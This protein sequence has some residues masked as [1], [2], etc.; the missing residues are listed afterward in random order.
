MTLITGANPNPAHVNVK[1]GQNTYVAAQIKAKIESSGT[2]AVWDELDGAV[3]SGV[4]SS[5]QAKIKLLS[6][7]LLVADWAVT[8]FTLRSFDGI[9]SADYHGLE[10]ACNSSVPHPIRS[11]I[12]LQCFDSVHWVFPNATIYWRDGS[13]DERR[14]NMSFHYTSALSSWRLLMGHTSWNM[15]EIYQIAIPSMSFENVEVMI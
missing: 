6:S 11:Y 14:L 4:G 15:R 1:V 2:Y 13:H 12:D 10:I 7:G 5:V 3:F 9:I 8:S